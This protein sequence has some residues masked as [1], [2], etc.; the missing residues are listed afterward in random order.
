M[1]GIDSKSKEPLVPLLKSESSATKGK[2]LE[3]L[4]SLVFSS[5]PGISVRQRNT[6]DD[7]NSQEID[8]VLWNDPHADGLPLPRG[9]LLV[10]AKNW[11]KPVGS[12]EIAWFD[13]KLRN[14]HLSFG[15]LV[16]NDG[17]TGDRLDKT[18]AYNIVYDALRNE[19]RNL[20]LIS[21]K[22]LL[23]LNS[24]EALAS[25]VKDKLCLLAANSDPLGTEKG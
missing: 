4:C 18:S 22:E 15:F 9:V 8:L 19:G 24:S 21:T 5:A 10:E 3:E 7:G 1:T 25:L 12:S 23:E 11:S 20:I 13:R 16:V 2:A 17:I 14:G 6:K